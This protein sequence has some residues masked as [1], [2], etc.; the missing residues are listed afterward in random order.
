MV[1]VVFMVVFMVFYEVFFVVLFDFISKSII[2]VFS[3]LCLNFECVS[4]VFI[5]LVIYTLSF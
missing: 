4:F 3:K 1:F 5:F 2:L